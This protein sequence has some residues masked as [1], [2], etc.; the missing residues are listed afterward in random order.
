MI[1]IARQKQ[2]GRPCNLSFRNCPIL[3]SRISQTGRS[4]SMDYKANSDW[5]RRCC[6]WRTNSARK[7]RAASASNRKS[8]MKN[9]RR[10]WARRGSGSACLCSAFITSG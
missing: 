8:R 5:A 6:N 2:Q 10:W 3:D 4:F 9:C 7:I 1:W